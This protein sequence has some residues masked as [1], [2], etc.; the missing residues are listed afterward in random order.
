SPPTPSRIGTWSAP[1]AW[2]AAHSSG[3][4]T[5]RR[6]AS[7]ATSDG[8]TLGTGGGNIPPFSPLPQQPRQ[9]A[10]A[11]PLA[12][13]L[14]GRAVLQRRVRERDLAHGVPADRARLSRSAVHPQAYLL[15]RFEITGGQ[16]ARAFDRIRERLDDG[17]VQPTP[18]LGAEVHRRLERRQLG[19]AQHLVRGRG[20][21]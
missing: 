11:P 16:A 21:G 18:F 15:L 19:H 7:P 8:R 5:S 2:P 12:A 3:S 14:T 4:R 9:P 13:G 10:A 20:F 1:A 6:N 17:G